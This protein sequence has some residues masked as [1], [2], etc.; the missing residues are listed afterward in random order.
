MVILSVL[1]VWFVDRKPWKKKALWL[2]LGIWFIALI[3]LMFVYRLPGRRSKT[4]LDIF[5]MFMEAVEYKGSIATNQA[6]RQILFNV[7]LYVPFGVIVAAFCRRI[8][9]MILLGIGLSV[10]TEAFQYWAGLGWADID[11]VVSNSIG[12]AFGTFLYCLIRE[13]QGKNAN[14]ILF[15]KVHKL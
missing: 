3:Y 1:V 5:H 7:L 11:D 6:L 4:V 10:L 2:M 12:L 14:I 13:M 8:W 9:L 15:E